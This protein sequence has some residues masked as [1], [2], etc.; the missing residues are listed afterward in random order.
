MKRSKNNIERNKLDY[1][2]TDIMPVEVSEL[3][4][5][6]KFYEYL[7]S[8]QSTLD[9]IVSQMHAMKAENSE[10]P[11]SGGKWGNWATSPLKFNILKGTDSIR[12]LNLVQPLSAMNIYFFVEC[13]QK[14]LLDIL[15]NNACFSL[16]YH[17]KNSDLFYRRKSKK[18]VDYFE[19][20]SQ[21]VD[22]A[23]L[24]QTGAYFKIHKFNSVSSFTNSRLWQQCNF[25]YRNF[26]KIDYKSCFDSIYTHAYKWCIEKD[27]VDSKEASNANLHIVIDRVLQNINGRSSNGLIVGPEFSRM[28]AEVL[29][30]EIDVEVK[31]NLAAQ[32][33]NA[34]TDY[35]VFRYVD[36]I[37]IFSHT[38][39]HTDLIIKTIERAAQKYLLKFNEFKYLKAYTPVVLSSWLGK[40]RALSDR[41]SALFYRKQEL[42]DM[43]E[44]KPL[45]KSG[46]ISVDRIKDD[47]IYLVN[48]FPKEQRYI[49]SFML[50]TLLN[51]ISN[52]KD[53]Y[54]LFE[55]DKCARAFVLLDL[56]MYIYSFC[57]C[58]EHTQKLISMIVYMDDELQFSK[59]ELN[60]KKLIN[61]IRRYSF[62]FEKGNMNDLC[63]WFVFFHDYSVPLLR[64][65]ETIFE[66]KLR[67][68]DNPILW[69][70]YLI[71]SRYH[72][73]YHQEI[74]TWVEEVLQYKVNQIGSK[75][76]LLQKEFWYVLTFINCPYISSSVKTALENI[77][78]PMATAAETNL[79]N[80]IKKIIAEFL[81]QN[82]SN[83]FFCWGYYHFNTSKQLTFR[84]YQRTLFKQYKNKRSIELYGSLD[85]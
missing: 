18:I 54:A 73:D 33:L 14:E 27:T 77:V 13:Y 42:H 68:E 45:L 39:A 34:G 57:P 53:G 23:I 5:Y 20:I 81:L 70:N 63:N 72:S 16:R 8:K 31:H 6:S 76:P 61:L 82:K 15:S 37:Y 41:I 17:R 71:Y 36:D 24:Q 25:K 7:L 60:H 11:F 26:S 56:A 32:G 47:F 35:R 80:K 43:A 21:K 51:N 59:D 67:E 50:S 12:E 65:T 46:Y 66:K 49:V 9:D 78:R 62:V 69:A 55:P 30:Q 74:L 1:I 38:Q 48:E 40:A 83:L 44:K 79:A 64:S 10:T 28:I 19:K 4:S 58:F 22:R 85:T 29:L 3:F 2:L 84:T 75:D 52:K